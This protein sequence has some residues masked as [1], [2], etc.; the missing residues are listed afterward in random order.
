MQAFTSMSRLGSPR[1]AAPLAKH[2]GLAGGLAGLGGGLAMTLVAALLTGALDQ[3]LWLQPKVIAS[4][5]LGSSAGEAAGFA[6]APVALGLLIH[7]GVAMLLGWLFAHFM[8]HIARLPS[9]FGVPEVAGVV[10]GLL[11][12]VVAY[13]VVLPLAAPGLLSI[14]APALLIQHLV[15]GASTG[16]LYG[17]LF[18]RPYAQMV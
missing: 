17:W 18:P 8:H 14:Y 9:D 7:L 15:Y 6:L 10:F 5:V 16:L 3:D 11:I 4:L 1:R 13:F 12:W 2:V